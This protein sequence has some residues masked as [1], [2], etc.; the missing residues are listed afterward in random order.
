VVKIQTTTS[1][2]PKSYIGFV[3]TCIQEKSYED[4]GIL[5]QISGSHTATYAAP[6]KFSK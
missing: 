4:N 5:E 6:A 2:I 3:R 1:G